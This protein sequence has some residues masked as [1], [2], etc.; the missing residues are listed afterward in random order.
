MA[1]EIASFCA[2]RRNVEWLGPKT[3]AQAAEIMANARVLVFPSKWYETFGRVAIESFA[4]GTPVIASRLGA[5]A[6][7]CEDQRTGL[8]FEAGNAGDLAEK[9]RWVLDHPESVAAMRGSARRA[10]EA[11]FTMRENCHALML[12]YETAKRAAR[13][14]NAAL[15]TPPVVVQPEEL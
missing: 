3:R 10:Y 2:E 14:T 13:G 1:G 9:L 12:A 6:E 15:E 8:L 7:I 4:A 11:R 5:M